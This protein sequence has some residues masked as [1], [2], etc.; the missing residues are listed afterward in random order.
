ML[1]D[2]ALVPATGTTTTSTT[3]TVPARAFSM[4]VLYADRLPSIGPPTAAIRRAP[5]HRWLPGTPP[6]RGLSPAHPAR[7]N[8]G[9]GF[10][11][12]AIPTVFVGN[13]RRYFSISVARR[14]N[15]LRLPG[16]PPVAVQARPASAGSSHVPLE[17]HPDHP[18]PSASR[19]I[20]TH[21]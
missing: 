4:V 19:G 5:R 6:C 7:R 1:I 14:S 17:G 11:A 9:L 12:T 8:R 10:F 2:F 18:S 3:A 13:A 16:R 21:A 15:Q 20:G